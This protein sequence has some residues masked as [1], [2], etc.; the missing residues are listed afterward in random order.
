VEKLNWQQV[1]NVHARNEMQEFVQQMS[2]MSRCTRNCP[3]FDLCQK[4]IL[5]V[6]GLTKMESLYREVIESSGGVFEYHNG[7]LNKGVKGLENLFKR[8]DVVLCP[9]SCNSHGACSLVKKLGKKHDKPVHF[10][11]NSSLSTI[12][13]AILE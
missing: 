2:Q 3:S 11:P 6:G 10:L 1:L 5:I 8:A 7:Y 13:Q 12:Y 9:I 4:R